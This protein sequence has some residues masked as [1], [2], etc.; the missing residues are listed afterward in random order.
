ML[1]LFH[2]ADANR[3]E[4]DPIAPRLVRAGFNCLA[5]DQRSG[6][7]LWAGRNLTVEALGHSTD[8]LGALPDLEAALA[9][10]RAAGHSGKVLVWGSSYSAA[11]VFLLAAKYPQE[12]AGVL[13]FSPAEYLPDKWAVRRAAKKLAIP[14]FITVAHGMDAGLDEEQSA[15][16]IYEALPSRGKVFYVPLILGRHGSATLRPD[17]NPLGMEE[18]WRAVLR[19]LRQFG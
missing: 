17:Q 14:V 15:R 7:G 3:H 9:W 18:N 4:Y 5:I 12:V 1:L 19:F 16:N 11:L 2:Q 8:F 13:A 10:A 6:G